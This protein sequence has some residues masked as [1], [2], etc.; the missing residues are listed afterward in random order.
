MKVSCLASPKNT[1]RQL[2]RSQN[3]AARVLTSHKRLLILNLY[4]GIQ[5]IIEEIL[6]VIVVYKLL[7][8]LGPKYVSDLF[9]E[10]TPNRSLGPLS[11]TML[12]T[13]GSNVL[14]ILDMIQV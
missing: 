11:A 14:M 13:D 8:N 9:K 1:I 7:N 10:Y 5:L 3:A 4:A 6:V 2:Q 12:Q